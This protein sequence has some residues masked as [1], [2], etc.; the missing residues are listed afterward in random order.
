MSQYFSHIY[1]ILMECLL[2]CKDENLND[3]DIYIAGVILHSP[4]ILY[5]REGL[6]NVGCMSFR[7]VCVCAC[8]WASVLMAH[9]P[10]G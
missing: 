1:L 9:Y 4:T 2:G 3:Q 5:S 8:V 7:F 10:H 6:K